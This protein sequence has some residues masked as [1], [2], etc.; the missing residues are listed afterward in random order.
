VGLDIQEPVAVR[1]MAGIVRRFYHP[2]ERKAWERAD[3]PAS[4]FV[5]LWCRKEA[6]AKQSGRGIDGAFAS[7]DAT[8][9]PC[10]IFGESLYLRDFHLPDFP[11]LFCA[12]AYPEPFEVRTVRF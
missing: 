10:T 7:F 11:A 2:A 1:R 9:D 6:A 5:R 12:A 3:D 8:E 4:E